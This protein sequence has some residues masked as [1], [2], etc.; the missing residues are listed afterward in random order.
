MAIWHTSRE[1]SPGAKQSQIQRLKR[2]ATPCLF[3]ALFGA[4][5]MAAEAQAVPAGFVDE[6]VASGLDRPVAMAFAPDGRLFIAEQAGA[7]RVLKGGS[8]RSSPFVRLSVDSTGDR[9]LRVLA[10]H[11]NFSANPLLYLSHTVPG[12][13]PH[14]R[15]TRFTASGDV[16]QPGSA[17]A[18]L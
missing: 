5:F 16:A 3:L 2:A 4:L 9:G 8:L 7:V 10:F 11:P 6:P 12:A 14:N 18:I 1:N 17:A 13:P 15:V